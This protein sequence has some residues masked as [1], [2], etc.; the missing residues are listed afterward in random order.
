[1]AVGS[2]WKPQVKASRLG[3]TPKVITSASESS[4]LPKSLVVLVM[5]AMRPSMRVKGDGEA[6][7][8]GGIVEM[9]RLL[10]RTLQ[11]LRNGEVAG[12]DIA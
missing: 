5:R 2:V 1:M 3:A 9:P 8:Q 4:S 6:D 11:A 7:G 10:H 12:G